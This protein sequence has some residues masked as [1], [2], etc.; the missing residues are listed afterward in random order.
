LTRIVFSFESSNAESLEDLTLTDL[1]KVIDFAN[2]AIKD[3]DKI[4]IA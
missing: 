3:E 4:E 2:P 1:V